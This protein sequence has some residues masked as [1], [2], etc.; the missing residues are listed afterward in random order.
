MRLPDPSTTMLMAPPPMPPPDPPRPVAPTEQFTPFDPTITTPVSC[1]RTPSVAVSPHYDP[2]VHPTRSSYARLFN[3]VGYGDSSKTIDESTNRFVLNNP[4]GVTRD[5]SYD[6]L[7]AYLLDLLEIGVDVIQLPEVN[8]DW[9]RPIEFQK[10]QSAVQSVFR[11]SKLST[12]SSTKRT[13]AARLPGGTLTIAVD[14]FTGR[15]S[16]SGRD[17]KYERWS[18]FKTRGRSGRTILIVPIYQVCNQAVASVGSTTAC[19]QQ[20]TLLDEA[21]RIQT[22]ASGVPYPHP[23]KALIQDF[24]EQLR[25]WRETGHEFII[26]GDLNEIIGDNPAEFGSITTEFN[27]VDI[28]CH[29]HGMDEPATFNGGHRRLDYILCSA[30]LLSTVKACGILPFNILSPSDHRTVFVNFDTKL[31]FGSLPSELAS[32]KDPQF[33]SRDYTSTP[34]MHTATTIKCT[35]WPKKRVRYGAVGYMRKVLREAPGSIPGIALCLGGMLTWRQ[36]AGCADGR[37][38]PLIA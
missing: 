34:C 9:R 19:L 36:S 28:Y 12:S 27:L 4:N 21:G 26:S 22:S 1:P 29:R 3:Q 31:L 17:S 10:C 23:R 30:P 35:R 33:K 13:T 37:T 18:C 32:C 5:G 16:G 20:H 24:S 2:Q 11:H 8:V 38:F 15:I 25:S 7:S 6:H 14:N